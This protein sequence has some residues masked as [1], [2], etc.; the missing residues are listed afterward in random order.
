MKNKDPRIIFSMA[1]IELQ[2][3]K[4]RNRLKEEM[5]SIEQNHHKI[6]EMCGVGHSQ[7]LTK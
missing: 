5:C 6:V 4:D 7:G 3:S 1:S 2:N